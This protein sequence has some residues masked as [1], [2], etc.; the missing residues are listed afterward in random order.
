MFPAMETK[1]GPKGKYWELP[2]EIVVSFKGTKLLA[3]LS[4]VDEV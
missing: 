1:K 4:W 3:K 2:F